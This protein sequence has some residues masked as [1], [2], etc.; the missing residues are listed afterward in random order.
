MTRKLSFVSGG[1]TWKFQ[2]QDKK[3]RVEELG[4]VFNKITVTPANPNGVVRRFDLQTFQYGIQ[5]QA[6]YGLIDELFTPTYNPMA[7]PYNAE[8]P[9]HFGAWGYID[10]RLI[11]DG[12]ATHVKGLE[13]A[14]GVTVNLSITN[15][16]T[17]QGTAGVKVYQP[18]SD[19]VKLVKVTRTL[20][21]GWN[22]NSRDEKTGLPNATLK[23]TYRQELAEGAVI[24][25]YPTVTPREREDGSINL[26]NNLQLHVQKLWEWLSE[27]DKGALDLDTAAR[28]YYT[29]KGQRNRAARNIEAARATG[30]LSE[31]LEQK[32]RTASRQYAMGEEVQ[33][34]GLSVKLDGVVTDITQIPSGLYAGEINGRKVY[35]D[36]NNRLGR[37]DLALAAQT[38]NSNLNLIPQDEISW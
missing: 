19:F 28:Q 31:E 11:E 14:K 32:V 15:P 20:Y 16:F 2:L 27:I 8:D 26:L 23:L 6:L 36:T 30:E 7:F 12:P 13:I 35:Y 38:H 3:H 22:D 18:T 25:L 17:R 33:E 24:E 10:S 1:K 37:M 29:A 9:E 21:Q 5:R 4:E 34:S